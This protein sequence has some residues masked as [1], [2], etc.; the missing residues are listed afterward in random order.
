MEDFVPPFS[1][2]I[3]QKNS[4]APAHLPSLNGELK[5]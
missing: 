3:S 4:K 1:G 5:E 2:V